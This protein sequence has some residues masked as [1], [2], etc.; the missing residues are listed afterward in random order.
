[1]RKDLSFVDGFRGRRRVLRGRK[2]ARDGRA[3]R[4]HVDRRERKD[5][6]PE[7]RSY[8]IKAM[9]TYRAMAI[10]AS[11]RIEAKSTR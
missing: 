7:L 4:R 6:S 10:R 3:Q 11:R 9:T 2:S 5:P 1:M 8:S